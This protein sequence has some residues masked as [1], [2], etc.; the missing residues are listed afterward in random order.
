VVSFISLR[1]ALRGVMEVVSF[2]QAGR[3]RG[4]GSGAGEVAP[5]SGTTGR[6]GQVEVPPGSF[7]PGGRA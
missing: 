6:Q 4:P 3:M 7:A 2:S 1:V 5:G